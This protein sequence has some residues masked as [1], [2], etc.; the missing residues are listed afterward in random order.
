MRLFALLLGVLW[1]L[2]S[3]ASD[4][5]HGIAFILRAQHPPKGV[6]FETVAGSENDLQRI[7]PRIR[8]AIER[9]RKRH[10]DLRF[11]VVSHGTE[12]FG[13][14]SSRRERLA[15]VHDAVRKL[16]TQD[17]PVHVCATHAAWEGFSR[18]DFPDY[19]DVAASGPEQIRAYQRQGYALIR[20]DIE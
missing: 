2:P 16:V 20:M 15:P 8:A 17:V 1:T 14:L 5:E 9:L 3:A 18:E 12:Q 19:V 4:S 13:L 11:A 6:V 7:L 10:P